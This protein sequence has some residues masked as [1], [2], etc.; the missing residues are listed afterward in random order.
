MCGIFGVI[1]A[2]P[3][4][5]IS[6]TT[7]RECTD[8]LAHRGPDGV[9]IYVGEAIAFGHRRL[10]IID[11]NQRANQPFLDP[12][13]NLLLTYNGEI[14]NYQ[15]LRS[16]LAA[17]GYLFT[18]SSDTEVL[19]KAFHKWGIT[20]LQRLRGMFAFALY[21]RNSGRTFLVRDRMG[22]KPLYYIEQSGGLLF[23]SQ[24]SAILRWPDIRK[25]ISAEALSSFLS[26]RA[27][28]GEGSFFEG[29][30]K[31]L[32][33]HYLEVI[34]GSAT[35]TKWWH[36][37]R[38]E[39]D[40]L[41]LDEEIGASITYHTISDVPLATFLSGGLDSS[42][43]TSEIARRTGLSPICFTGSVKGD[44][45]D[46]SVYA[47]SVAT[48]FGLDH[49]IVD[50]PTPD[51]VSIVSKLIALRCHPLGMHNE[52]AMYALARAISAEHKVALTGEGADE[53]F[54]GYGRL[55]RI[56]L[57]YARAHIL[58]MLPAAL[59]APIAKRLKVAP[60]QSSEFDFFLHHYSYFPEQQ[61][62]KLFRKEV[63]A[64]L[65]DGQTRYGTLR[66]EFETLGSNL[67]S[68]VKQF[69]LQHHLPAL[70]EMVD[71]T[72]MAAGIEARVP[73]V[74][75]CV[76]RHAL[77]L[78]KA[79]IIRWRSL[80]HFLR[81]LV[82][83]IAAFSE[84]FDTTKAILRDLY[85]DVLPSVVLE[86]PKVGFALPLGK[87]ATTDLSLPFRNRLFSGSPAAAQFLDMDAVRH[88]YQ[89]GCEAPS[90]TFGRQVWLLCNVELFLQQ[91]T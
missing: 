53:L 33:G 37:A 62:E 69:M 39:Q 63:R 56:D 13:T 7:V 66:T 77:S 49:R 18:T 50:I 27:V 1:N 86:R 9:G 90:D 67:F 88:W 25:R 38:H 28:Y 29:L 52:L 72:T 70:L 91:H 80:F 68:R 82:S 12:E 22:I 44:G 24:P 71:N 78:R 35:L 4:K 2:A 30:K 11:V 73:F 21:D 20:C 55:Y 8:M 19:C 15:D 46:E 16:E 14:F 75:D 74:D 42:I 10:A 6:P 89:R 48:K 57:D 34:G 3:G 45:Y 83:P 60:Y 79:D 23:A 26:F 76:I 61:K 32:P 43:I 5:T 31:V 36:L 64:N 47:R 51:D 65:G 41:P 58:A 81:A 85:R 40:A 84:R 17:C 59:A 87:W 54:A